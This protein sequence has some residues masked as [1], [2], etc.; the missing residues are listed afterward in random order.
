M[1]FLPR[2]RDPTRVRWGFSQAWLMGTPP[3]LRGE[4]RRSGD[5]FALAEM[6]A[7]QPR[8]ARLHG[9]VLSVTVAGPEIS[10]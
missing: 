4:I 1:F 9:A 8:E 6:Y 10:H 7:F 3:S 2:M 5:G